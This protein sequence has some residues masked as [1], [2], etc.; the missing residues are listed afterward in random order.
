MVAE[1]ERGV[2]VRQ[3][4]VTTYGKALKKRRPKAVFTPV[5]ASESMSDDE[6]VVATKP[7]TESRRSPLVPAPKPKIP[8]ARFKS[9]D[10]TRDTRNTIA[11]SQGLPSIDRKRKVSQ[12]YQSREQ[13]QPVSDEEPPSAP[14]PRRSRV[15]QPDVTNKEGASARQYSPP[16]SMSRDTIG[17]RLS[18]PPPT[19]TPPRVSKPVAKPPSHVPRRAPVNLPST[20]SVQKQPIPHQHPI[21]IH[22][23]RDLDG[24]AKQPNP[25]SRTMS[26]EQSQRA[27]VNKSRGNSLAKKPRKRLIDALVEQESS[28]DTAIDEDIS[29]TQDTSSQAMF[30]Q[31]SSANDLDNQ[32][33]LETP[34]PKVRIAPATGART[35]TRSSSALKFTYGQGRKVLEEED[36]LLE[37][38]ALPSDSYSRRRLDLGSPKKPTA[39]TGSFDYDDVDDGSSKS[40]SS[41][42]RGIHELR[43]AGA[44]S[45]V[46]D[47]MQDMVDQI[48]K[49]G[50]NLSSRRAAL[51]QVTEKMRDK[52]FI[53]QCLDH[54]V[55]NVMLKD[56]GKETDAICTYLILSSLAMII[57]N[58]SSAHLVSLLRTEQAG[59]AF[60][61]LLS[62]SEDIKKV[63]RDRKTNLS[64]RSQTSIIGIESILRDLSI[65]DGERPS[66]ISPRNLAIKCLQLLI[67][68]DVLIGGDQSIV[69]DAV[70]KHLFEVLS[71]ASSNSEYWGYPQTAR[72]VE[73]CGALSVLDVHA[74][75]MTATRRGNGEWAIGYLPLI[76]DAFYTSLQ[77]PAHDGKALNDLILK[78][79]I[80]VT[81]NNLAAPDVF[82]SKGLLPALADSISR[83]FTQALA[84]IS[85]DTGADGILDSLVLRLG[86]LINFAEHSELVRQMVND[87]EYEGREPVNE[88]I[89]LFIDNHRRTGEA[90][91]MEKTH[92]NVAFGYLSVLLGYLA[93]HRPV[94]RKLISIH[95]AKSIGPLIGSIREFIAHYEQVENAISESQDDDRPHGSF[96]EGLQQLVQQL[97]DHAARD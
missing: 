72:S 75:S 92:L 45:R 49:P 61:R 24:K 47:A 19:P 60:A 68:Q 71:D 91:S 86:I 46:A 84:L 28:D 56:I 94:R 62:I 79:T 52:S 39:A 96:V 33:S 38:L 77:T 2:Q 54:G 9:L 21:P 18:S 50:A 70:T 31:S 10:E 8:S 59:S 35:F 82:A 30:S 15:S 78:L 26:Q 58:G 85:Q 53:R 41:K 23:A 25:L 67:A 32:S 22:L 11:S 4:R 48:G 90:D 37:S 95:S 12:I 97:E 64:K 74:V 16:N 7:V 69:T 5:T 65:W 27:L 3:K 88:L 44:N 36:D 40:P 14:E 51:L 17:P 66:F 42:L 29:D 87:C 55:D 6:P 34:K 93:L 43:Q 76:A 13:S 63:A 81:N 20:K 89:R 57:T 1:F 73:L 83:N 80:N